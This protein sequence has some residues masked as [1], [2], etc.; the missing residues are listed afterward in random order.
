MW[1]KLGAERQALTTEEYPLLGWCSRRFWPAPILLIRGQS[2]LSGWWDTTPSLCVVQEPTGQQLL[3][4]YGRYY[5][6]LI[7]LQDS[8]SYP[9]AAGMLLAH[10]PQLSAASGIALA[11]AGP[12]DQGHDMSLRQSA[13]NDCSMGEQK[14]L[15]S[16]PHLGTTLEDHPSFRVPSPCGQLR[17]LCRLI[18]A[19]L[20]PPPNLSTLP[21]T[22]IKG[23][24]S[25]TLQTEA[26]EMKRLGKRHTAS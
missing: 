23:Y 24:L 12:L 2:G 18:T 19:H 7:S 10:S 3:K 26:R 4:Q 22:A 13:S 15:A 11:V 25:P 21:R 17:S 16:L 6:M 5:D 8:R 14:G 1:G 20:L 9:P